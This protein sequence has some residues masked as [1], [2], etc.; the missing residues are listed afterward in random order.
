MSAV[1]VIISTVVSQFTDGKFHTVNSASDPV[2]EVRAYE[3]TIDLPVPLELGPMRIASRHYTVVEVHCA[4]GVTGVA[5][6][7]T[8]NAPVA[9][10][11]ERLLAPVLVGRDADDIQARFGEMWGTTIAVGR[12]GLVGRAI[13]LVDIALWDARGQ[14]HGAPV[15]ELLGG[16]RREIPVMYVAGYPRRPADVG[17]VVAAACAAAREGHRT[18]KVARAPD[19]S[20]TRELIAQLDRELPEPARIV[21][22]GNWAWH[23]VEDAQAELERW[24][25]DRIA[26]VEDPFVPEQPAMLAELRRQAAVPIAA[27]DDLTDPVHVG[28]LLEHDAVDVLRLDVAAIGGISAVRPL[29]AAA[30]THGL[31]VSFHISPEASVHVAAPPGLAVDVETFDRRGNPFDPSHELFVGGP[32]FDNGVAAPP[33]EPGLGFTIAP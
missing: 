1:G 16:E 6:A 11:V 15:Y 25:T 10:V 23:S 14:R 17:D 22:D 19:P 30:A 2:A 20:L 18:V 32:V 7:Q 8:R 4:S 27:G 5:A 13:S 28:R 3:R 9:E 21:I 29:V 31:P 33:A 12:G 26:W 24:A